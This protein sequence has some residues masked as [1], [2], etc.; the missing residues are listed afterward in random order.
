MEHFKKKKIF[1][2]TSEIIK[3]LRNNKKVAKLNNKH[4]ANYYFKKLNQL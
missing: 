2:S 4:V 1:G 3:F